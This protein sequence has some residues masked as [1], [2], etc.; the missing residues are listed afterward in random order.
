MEFDDKKRLSEIIQNLNKVKGLNVIDILKE[1]HKNLINSLEERKNTGVLECINRQYTILISHNS[2]F[3]ESE[4]EI[5]KKQ[6]NSLLFPPVKFSEVKAL[7]VVSSSPSLEVHNKLLESFNLNLKLED[8]TL[9]VGFDL[10]KSP[11]DHP[12]HT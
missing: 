7:N 3:R 9:L 4:G 11:K 5:V 10:T 6:G 2:L 8:A 12:E 1:K